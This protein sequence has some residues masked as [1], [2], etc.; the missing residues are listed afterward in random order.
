M[1]SSTPAVLTIIFR[2]FDFIIFLPSRS[3]PPRSFYTLLLH[4]SHLNRFIS[5]YIIPFILTPF[6]LLMFDHTIL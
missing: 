5:F 6:I 2:Y 4:P 3:L 1:P